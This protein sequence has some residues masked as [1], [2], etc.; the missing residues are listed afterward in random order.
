V[1]EEGAR[2][3]RAFTR[4]G[5]LKAGGTAA[6]A[7]GLGVAADAAVGAGAGRDSLAH[8]R[9]AS[10]EPLLHHVFHIDHPHGS[11]E[12]ELIEV[13]RLRPGRADGEHFSLVFRTARDERVAQGTYMLREPALGSFRLFLVPVGRDEKKKGSLLQ[14]VINRTEA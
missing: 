13:E 7:L 5:F 4:G 8:L 6:A 11:I 1:D 14:A 9:L 3:R 12:A 2:S 10:Y